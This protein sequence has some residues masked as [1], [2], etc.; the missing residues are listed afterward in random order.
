MK[1]SWNG[2]IISVIKKQNYPRTDHSQHLCT[3]L[4]TLPNSEVQ[5][6]VTQKIGWY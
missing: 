3:G 6:H 1:D 2:K 5:S 4:A